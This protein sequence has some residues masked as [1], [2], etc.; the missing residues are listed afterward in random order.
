MPIKWSDGGKMRDKQNAVAEIKS[1]YISAVIMW[2]NPYLSE[3]LPSI[4]GY[5][6]R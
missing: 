1:Y 3:C 2:A 5:L 6:T 4:P